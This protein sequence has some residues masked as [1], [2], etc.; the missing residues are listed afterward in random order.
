MLMMGV[1]VLNGVHRWFTPSAHF[2]SKALLQNN[3]INKAGQLASNK[4]VSLEWARPPSRLNELR[5][6]K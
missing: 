3:L 2:Q 5:T 6:L 1:S 4:K